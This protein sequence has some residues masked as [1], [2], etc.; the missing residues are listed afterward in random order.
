MLGT[1][2]IFNEKWKKIDSNIDPG[3][4]NRPA[5]PLG[6][7]FIRHLITPGNTSLSQTQHYRIRQAFRKK[8]CSRIRIR[9]TSERIRQVSTRSSRRI[10][11]EPIESAT[12]KHQN[13]SI[14]DRFPSGY[15]R[16][17]SS[18]FHSETR[19]FCISTK[20]EHSASYLH[21]P[22]TYPNSTYTSLIGTLMAPTCL[23]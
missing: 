9:K 19:S 1:T 4:L 22:Y 5:E 3:P 15:R 11:P 23:P 10:L 6:S 14:L 21:I 16:K 7:A 18:K 17:L 13:A 20:Q 12:R 8:L 2:L